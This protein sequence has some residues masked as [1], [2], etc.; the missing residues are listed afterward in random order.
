LK[1]SGGG[2]DP[3]PF[4]GLNRLDVLNELIELIDVI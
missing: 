3:P 4:N 2:E 1:G